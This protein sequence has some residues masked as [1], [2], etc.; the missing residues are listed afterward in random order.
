[1]TAIRTACPEDF[2]RIMS[3]Y[4][5]V[6]NALVHAPC[7]PGWEK[8]IYP[9]AADVL[10]F[11]QRKEMYIGEAEGRIAC[12]M[13]LNRAQ[14]DAQSMEIHLLAVHPDFRGRGLGRELVRFAFETAGKLGKK[15]ICLDVT[16]GNLP[17]EKLY[18]SMGFAYVKTRRDWFTG[19]D[20]LD[21]R[22]FEY[23]L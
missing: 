1:M 4:E 16:D 13:A 12:A 21:F 22:E 9:A 7:G 6:M 18:I 8:D 23:V 5:A 3:L 15:K 14:G 20:Y 11:L 10:P 17:A 19:D 2:P